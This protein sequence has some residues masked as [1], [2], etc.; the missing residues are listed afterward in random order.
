ME[1]Y[2]LF[3]YLDW[4]AKYNNVNLTAFQ[5]LWIEKSLCIPFPFQIELF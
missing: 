5:T 1:D 4:L 2:I 3:G